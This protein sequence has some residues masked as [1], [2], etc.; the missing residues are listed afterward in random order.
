[1]PQNAWTNVALTWHRL[2][3]FTVYVDSHKIAPT[4]ATVT[5]AHVNQSHP[6]LALAR[7]NDMPDGFADFM[8]HSLV[9]WDKYIHP[10]NV[11]KLLGV[12]GSYL[13]Q[14]LVLGFQ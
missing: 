10:K 6:M 3:P 8:I 11:H 14:G 2:E 4:S 7:R 13:T 9:V 5:P 12:S 1:M